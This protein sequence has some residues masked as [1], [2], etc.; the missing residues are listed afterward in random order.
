MDFMLPN[1]VVGGFT[2]VTIVSVILAGFFV[3]LL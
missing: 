3:K 1:M 2:S